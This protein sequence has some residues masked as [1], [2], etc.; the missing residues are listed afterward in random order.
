MFPLK[1][2]SSALLATV[3]A[4]NLV[5]AKAIPQNV[6]N[7]MTAATG[8]LTGCSA[9]YD[10]RFGLAW[11]GAYEFVPVSPASLEPYSNLRLAFHVTYLSFLDFI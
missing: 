6:D 3:T 1:Y 11:V 10:G 5:I 4:I 8:S 7:M 9:N 2:S